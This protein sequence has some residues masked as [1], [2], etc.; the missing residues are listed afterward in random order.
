MEDSIELGNDSIELGNDLSMGNKLPVGNNAISLLSLCNSN[1][2]LANSLVST[3]GKSNWLFKKTIKDFPSAIHISEPLSCSLINKLIRIKGGVIKTY[4]IL[5]KNVVS[6]KICLKC[7]EGEQI[8]E[9]ESKNNTNHICIACGSMNVRIN[10]DFKEAIP[11]QYIRIQDI[12]NSKGITETSEIFL[13]GENAG[14]V[15]PG[16]KIAVVG[17]VL[18]R[19][20][21]LKPCEQMVSSLYVRALSVEKIALDRGSDEDVA[22]FI[23]K[24]DDLPLYG[25]RLEILS[26]FAS[27]LIG[28]DHIR[29]GML[30]GLVGGSSET[31][32]RSTI[33]ILLIGDPA[34]GKS[35]LLKEVSHLV[36]PC[37]MANGVSTSDAGLTTCAVRQGR[38]WSLEAGALVLADNGVCCIDEFN[39]LRVSEKSG[40]L[41]SMEQQTISVAK[42]GIVTS[43]NTRCSVYAA[44]STR[45]NYDGSTTVS[46]NL[47]IS[48]ALVSRFDLIFGL[49]ADTDN[50]NSKSVNMNSKTV[51]MN[52]K[53]DAM[54]SNTSDTPHNNTINTPSEELKKVNSILDRDTFISKHNK[55]SPVFNLR[56]YIETCKK[57]RIRMGDECRVIILGYYSKR[58]KMEGHNEFN[59]IRMLEGVVRMAEAHGKLMGRFTRDCGN[60]AI[61]SDVLEVT[62]DDVVMA[63][64]LSEMTI[65]ASS[66]IKIDK[67]LILRDEEYYGRIKEEMLSYY[68]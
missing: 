52:S 45:C 5:L 60:P 59:T 24:L 61:E 18:R 14:T 36:V 29:L 64:I 2:K 30:L 68:V 19:W 65:N 66:V 46:D 9:N 1:P 49:F 38:E 6:E 44:A 35:H 21:M 27:N 42:A 34:T 39:R 62:K 11:S 20:K 33:H 4:K 67:N 41:E 13:E 10:R 57:R 50:M 54:N 32:G 17:V 58:R 25:R 3:F 28:I 31:S 26:H 43:L 8:V 12:G 51:N 16:E 63:M 37:V 47:G 48:P 15:S 23:Q 40:L 22:S 7:N 53:T 55:H 56:S